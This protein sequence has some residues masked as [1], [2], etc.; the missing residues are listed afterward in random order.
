[1]AL[2]PNN[3]LIKEQQRA[4]N[5]VKVDEIKIGEDVVPIFNEKKKYSSK[6]RKTIQI[7]PPVLSTIRNLAYAKNVKIYT[8]VEMAV[9]AYIDSLSESEKAIFDMQKK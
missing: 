1:M 6:E 8:L 4:A 9:N 7:D 2:I 5:S 3:K